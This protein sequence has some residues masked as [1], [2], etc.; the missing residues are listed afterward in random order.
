[1]IGALFDSD[2]YKISFHIGDDVIIDGTH[3]CGYVFSHVT[4]GDMYLVVT[5]SGKDRQWCRCDEL[6]T[7]TLAEFHL[8]VTE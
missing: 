1:M 4:D 3:E 6:K 5:H 2:T 7:L 8:V